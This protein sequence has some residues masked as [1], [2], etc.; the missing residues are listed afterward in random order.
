MD[1]SGHLSKRQNRKSLTK[2]FDIKMVKTFQKPE[3]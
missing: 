1:T 2:I 3:K